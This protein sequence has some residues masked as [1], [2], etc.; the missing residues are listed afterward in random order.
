MVGRC[1]GQGAARRIAALL[2]AAWPAPLPKP[3]AAPLPGAAPVCL[4]AFVLALL[5]ALLVPPARAAA[6]DAAPALEIYAME[7]RP[8]SFHAADGP[9][10][11]VVDMARE[12][13]RRIGNSDPVTI[14]PWARA[15][16]LAKN[17]ANVLLLSII[18]TAER[19]RYLRYVGPVFQLH[20]GCYAMRSRAAELRARDP[21]LHS[22][23]GGARRG[24]IF[25]QLARGAGYHLA[26]EINN[27]DL[28]IRMLM[29]GRYDLLFDGD[30]I[31]SG[32][33]QR[34]GYGRDQLELMADLGAKSVYF[35]F[36]QGTPDSVV[37]AW[38]AALRA[39]R[40]D[41]SYQ[42]I[43]RQWLPGYPLP[44]ET[45]AQRR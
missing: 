19:D 23:R 24:S 25:I 32:A 42:K 17:K 33:L 45:A 5:L 26:E 20:L 41:G 39:M 34:T 15:N 12:I 7:A 40:R 2:P 13:Q 43:H 4:L 14:V 16:L 1:A 22:L 3:Q 21:S 30:E 31:V 35:A 28:A 38:D 27:S 29:A 44:P 37:Q 10:G 6:A 18:P 36:S 9:S 8:I 11:L